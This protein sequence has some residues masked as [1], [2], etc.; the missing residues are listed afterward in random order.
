[1]NDPMSAPEK[2]RGGLS[3][4]LR[5]LLLL[6][7]ILAVVVFASRMVT[8]HQLSKQK[9]QLLDQKEAYEEQIKRA[10]YD[11]NDSIDYEDIIRIAREKFN[12]AFPDDT[13]I[14][15]GQGVQP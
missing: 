9:D 8:F 14:Y 12:L 3:L 2:S 4:G 1:M 6:I 7:L 13:V 11:M 15:S 5:C 10:E